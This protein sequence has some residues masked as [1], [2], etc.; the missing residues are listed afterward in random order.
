MTLIP[1][2]VRTIFFVGACT[3][4]CFALSAAAEKVHMNMLFSMVAL[5]LCAAYL[6]HNLVHRQRLSRLRSEY[7]MKPSVAS[8]FPETVQVV[9]P[10]WKKLVIQ[11]RSCDP[12]DNRSAA[13]QVAQIYEQAQWC[14]V[15]PGLASLVE[16]DERMMGALAEVYSHQSRQSTLKSYLPYWNRWVNFAL[17]HRYNIW[18]PISRDSEEYLDFEC[19][20]NHFAL[21]EY[22]RCR[23]RTY[24]NGK[25]QPNLP[26]TFAKTFDG[27]NHVLRDLFNLKEVKTNEMARMKKAYK[28]FGRPTK[29]ARP[30]QGKHLRKL[31]ELADKLKRPWLTLVAN[32]AVVAWMSAGRWDCIYNINVTKSIQHNDPVLGAGLDPNGEYWLLYFS[33]R[34]NRDEE[35]VTECLTFQGR[36]LLNPRRCFM[37]VVD[38]H[39][40]RFAERWLPAC[41]KVYNTPHWKV[42]N[43]ISRTCSYAVFLDMFREAMKLAGL[44]KEF[45][46]QDETR[47]WSLHAF[48]RGWVTNMRR[49]NFV[50]RVETIARHGNWNVESV[51]VILSYAE[52][53]AAEH[54]AALKP[55]ILHALFG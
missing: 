20:Y 11:L 45:D 29:K 12:K 15:S 17:A 8:R 9:T 51:P 13:H 42:V 41:E 27:V 6:Q 54:A 46:Y 47:K 43:D 39:D 21:S 22:L 2:L 33:Q 36:P 32:T 38:T 49:N 25:V 23:D 53:S 52:S 18:P 4:L 19:K 35:T 48:R 16:G 1:G 30:M 40:R 50:V 14:P 37:D 7:T 44:E 10:F 24:K 28:V 26:S 34:K 3:W 55:S 31:V 5:F